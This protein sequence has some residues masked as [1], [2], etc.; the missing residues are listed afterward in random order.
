MTKTPT[1]KTMATAPKA[2]QHG[3]DL[4]LR[5]EWPGSNR[6]VHLPAADCH[7]A[8]FRA[9]QELQNA[10]N[11]YAAARDEAIVQ[12]TLQEVTSGRHDPA[13]ARAARDAANTAQQTCSA[14]L[15]ALQQAIDETRPEWTAHVR[16][17]AAAVH[18]DALATASAF[19][20]LAERG[21][22]LAGLLRWL[23]DDQPRGRV[24]GPT[25][26]ASRARGAVSVALEALD[27]AL[28]V[29]AHEL[30]GRFEAKDEDGAT[31]SDENG[32]LTPSEM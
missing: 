4:D 26:D 29:L 18:A 22:R 1:T 24:L 10:M 9:G 11:A 3:R 25:P 12:R 2:W 15:A 5:L 16:E 7:P 30:V 13:T 17:Q 32:W 8:V 21:A 19:R 23:E 31:S 27:G 20:A 28:N 14:G 6:R